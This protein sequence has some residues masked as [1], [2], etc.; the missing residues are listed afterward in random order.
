VTV[1]AVISI[2]SA[3]PTVHSA[4]KASQPPAASA[5]PDGDLHSFAS[6]LTSSRNQGAEEQSEQEYTLPKT[7]MK[8]KE[9]SEKDAKKD[10]DSKKLTLIAEFSSVPAAAMPN[11]EAKPFLL[12]WPGAVKEIKAGEGNAAAD[13]AESA[14]ADA[15]QALKASSTATLA[16]APVAFGVTLSKVEGTKTHGPS[17]KSATVSAEASSGKTTVESLKAA[18]NRNPSGRQHSGSSHEDQSLS[19]NNKDVKAVATSAKAQ[20]ETVGAVHAVSSAGQVSPVAAATVPNAYAPSQHSTIEK[21]APAAP[22]AS[23]VAEPVHAPVLR[24]QNIDLKIAGADNRE[25]DV[26][27]S[28][29][30]GDVQVT[31]RTPDG[32]LAQSLRQHL[33]ELSDR[34]SQAGASGEIWQ[35]QQAQSAST[36]GNDADSR[37]SDDAQTQQQQHQNQQHSRGNS[38]QGSQQQ[39]H[40]TAES[41]WLNQLNQAEKERY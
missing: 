37:Y 22:V 5:V 38:H 33:P 29:R 24:P 14:S 13:T 23:V 34:L 21:A 10:G 19:Q 15:A 32:E 18:E 25:V 26:R 8:G 1:I 3:P 28:Q 9:K 30:A 11:P 39:D 31:V 12:S 36:G 41:A 4:P 16:K 2:P 17:P 20:T 35:P 27:V 7:S 40:E 6:L